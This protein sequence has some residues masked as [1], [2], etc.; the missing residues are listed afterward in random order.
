[1]IAI[2]ALF[3]ILRDVSLGRL[4]KGIT[5]PNEEE[6]INAQFADDT[7]L[8]LELSEDNFE[9][10]MYRLNFFCFVSRAKVA[11]HKSVVMGWED[12]HPS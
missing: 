7:S 6:L 5:L 10:S 11:P 9:V 3:Y 2:D 4:I 1:M 12:S 8:F